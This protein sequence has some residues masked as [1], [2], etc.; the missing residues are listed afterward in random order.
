MGQT[1][2]SWSGRVQCTSYCLDVWLTV[3]SQVETYFSEAQTADGVTKYVPRSVQIDLEAGV[4]NRVCRLAS[5]SRND[6]ST[7]LCIAAFGASGRL[8]SSGHIHHWRVWSR[9]QLGKGL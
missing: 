4:C 9:E 8:V 6:F 5:C 3:R 2:C 1:H 7:D